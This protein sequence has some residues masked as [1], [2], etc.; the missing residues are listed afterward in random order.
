LWHFYFYLSSRKVLTRQGICAALIQLSV[1]DE[2][3]PLV[4]NLQWYLFGIYEALIL[5]LCQAF[6]KHS[7]LRVLMTDN[8]NGIAMLAEEITAGLANAISFLFLADS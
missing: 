2:S 1:I 7:L 5:G 8:E 6:M 4:C 3:S